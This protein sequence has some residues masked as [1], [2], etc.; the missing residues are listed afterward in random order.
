MYNYINWFWKHNTPRWI[1]YIM[2]LILVLGALALAF[3]IRF[4]FNN[5]PDQDLKNM[6]LDFTLVLGIRA[7]SFYWSKLYKGVIRYTSSKDALRIFLVVFSG[8][9]LIESVNLVL[10][11]YQLKTFVLPHSIVIIEFLLSSFLLITIRMFAKATYY[12]S[13]S[14]HLKKTKVF[15]FGA[16]ESGLLSK[17]TLDGDPNTS[18]QVI[19]FFDDDIKKNK[20]RIEG[21]QVLSLQRLES[22]LKKHKPELLLITPQQLNSERKQYI[23]DL[24][25]KYHVRVLHVPPVHSWINGQLSVKQFKPLKIEDLLERD[26]IRIDEIQIRSAITGKTILITG[27]AG[28][29]GST[30][31]MQC[32]KYQPQQLVL[33]DQAESPLYELEWNLK[34]AYPQLNFEVVLGDVRNANRLNRVFEFF[35]PH[36]VFHA[37]AYKHV[38]L[39]EHNPSESILTNVLGS[40]LVADFAK[41][42][43][44]ERFVMISTDKAVNPTNVM[45]ASKR[46]AEMYVQS[47]Q[48]SDGPKFITTRF[49]NV[50]GSNGSVIPRFQKQ[51]EQGGPITVTHPEIT[52]FFMTMDEAGVL[53][54][55]ASAMGSGGEIFVFDM[56]KPVRIAELAKKMILLSGLIPE[57][58]IQIQYTGLRPGEKL[59]EEL[60]ANEENTLP[61]HHPKI[62]IGKT[63]TL[64]ASSVQHQVNELIQAFETQ[65]NLHIVSLM[66]SL[67]PEYISMNSEFNVLDK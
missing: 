14:H 21:L 38:P 3:L 34:S 24:C 13:K 27:A 5:I 39:M 8:S 66:K 54:L 44:V 11:L 47:L 57:T 9:I 20:L 7:F 22:M 43:G 42:F 53:V 28:S 45:G 52:R 23:T 56:G 60:L 18:Y 40:K 41:Q 19:V 32:A 46:I 26:A 62:L 10:W 33:F 35:K 59:Y 49:G 58:E 17:R 16:G 37:A 63:R 29:I 51:I 36:L 6:P 4:D 67:V 55:E 65:N 31:A 2:D 64:D 48:R 50:L 15:I 30:L 61:T 25:F 12:Q 1:I